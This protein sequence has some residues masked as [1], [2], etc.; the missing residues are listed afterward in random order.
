MCNKSLVCFVCLALAALTPA[1][2]RAQTSEAS[3]T[4]RIAD[5]SDA[6]I[7][8]APVVV[9]NVDT[10]VS[11]DTV[12]SG[13]GNYTIPFLIPGRYDVS[14]SVPGFKK[15]TRSGVTLQ[16]DQVA[17]VDFALEIGAASESVEVKAIAA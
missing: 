8:G 16:V 6:P 14:V 11:R 13:T 5:P 12:S 1:T 2:M 4:G 17:R 15:S 3:I 9:T 10:G 7:A